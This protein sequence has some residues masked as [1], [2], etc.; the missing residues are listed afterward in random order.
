MSRV[1][2]IRTVDTDDIK[3]AT[4]FD[5]FVTLHPKLTNTEIRSAL[6]IFLFKGEDVFKE[7]KDLS[8]GEKARISLL[9]I[10]LSESN[11]LILDE[12]TNHLDMVTKEC[13]LSALSSYEGAILFISHDRYFANKIAKKEI[14]IN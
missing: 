11:F 6:A 2:R 13:L 3:T 9:K 10:M 14:S 1:F 5:F 8:G 4:V 7:I 12:P